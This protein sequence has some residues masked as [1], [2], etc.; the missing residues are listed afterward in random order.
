MRIGNMTEIGRQLY[1]RNMM[2]KLTPWLFL[3]PIL[4]LHFIVKIGPSVSAIYYSMT[5]WSGIGKAEFIGLDNFRH[6][7]LEDKD[8][9]LA[10]LHNCLW[11]SFSVITFTMAL[12][13]ATLLAPIKRGGLAFR[14]MLF[15]PFVLPS[16]VTAGIWRNLMNP[17]LGIGAQLAKIGIPGLDQAFLGIPETSLLAVFFI[18]NWRWWVFIMLLLLTAMQNISIELYESARVDGVTVWQEFI[19]ITLPGIRPTLMFLLLMTSIWTFM[20]FDYV[21]ILTR[22]GPAGSSEVLGTLVIKNAFVRFEA[23]YASAIGI[24]MT[25]FSAVFIAIFVILRK[26][27]WEI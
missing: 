25:L 2:R 21:W 15:I 1:R 26:K 17:D 14:T 23:G 22:G 18:D 20:V 24:T 9:K 11:L 3:I 5:E 27:G 16:V 19:H 8:F 6:L 12:F 4:I 7:I 13:V 10:F